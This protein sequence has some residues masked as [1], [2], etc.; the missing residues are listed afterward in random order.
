MYHIECVYR[1]HAV[2]PE[3]EVLLTLRFYATGSF[4]CVYADFHGIHVSTTSCIVQLVSKSIAAL[5]TEFISMPS[6]EA[7][8]KKVS[9]EFH[10]IAQFPWCIGA[11]DCTH[12]RI[13]SPGG[14]NAEIYRNRKG[15]FLLNIQTISYANLNIQNIVA[16]WL[17]SAHDSNIFR[18][19]SPLCTINS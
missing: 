18:N 8:K 10:S 13:R 11:M 15:W 9:Q 19:S 17:G 14:E 6:T 5:H 4:L 3:Q 16:G 1:N 2:T 12:V 7:G